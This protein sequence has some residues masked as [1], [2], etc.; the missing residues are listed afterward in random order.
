MR[1]TARE[2]FL[3]WAVRAFQNSCYAS[4]EP[5]LCLEPSLSL[6]NVDLKRPLEKACCSASFLFSTRFEF[7]RTIPQDV[8]LPKWGSAHVSPVEQP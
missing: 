2:D 8:R 3:Q 1:D 6:G 5:P 4:R 7:V